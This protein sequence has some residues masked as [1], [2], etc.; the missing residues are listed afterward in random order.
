VAVD[1]DPR[2]AWA[3]T[4]IGGWLVVPIMLAVL[5]S[6]VGQSIFLPRNLLM[7]LP[8]VAMIVASV[9]LDPRL[10]SAVGWGG[11]AALLALRALQLA[12]SYGVSPEDW[13]VASAYVTAATRAG[14]CIAFY[15]A[16]GR[17]AFA[18]YHGSGRPAPQPVLPPAPWTEVKPY[19]ED[20]DTLS[21]AE[22]TRLPS[23]CERL[24]FVFSHE[25]QRAGPPVSRSNYARF[26]ALQNGLDAEFEP[27]ATR[28]FGYAAPVGVQLLERR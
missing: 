23:R 16:D 11:V 15:P 4:L 13:R 6:L 20:Y 3:A 10:P 18:Y 9:L 17:M 12:P 26:V 24:W 14:D 2:R 27:L 5:E 28:S 25:G 19:V 1:S 21:A 8:P 7:C 22:L